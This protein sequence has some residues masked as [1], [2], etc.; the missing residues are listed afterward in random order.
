MYIISTIPLV[1]LAL[2]LVPSL[3][4]LLI[5][6]I[7][8]RIVGEIVTIFSST[9]LLILSVVILYHV[10]YEGS[11]L[12]FGD[13]F[14]VDFL[15]A[16]LLILISFIS[17]IASLYS[18]KYI[19]YE[20]I[21]KKITKKRANMYYALF[22]IFFFTMVLLVTTNNIIIM[23]VALE[24]TTLA[25]AYL[26]AI[27]H[28][29][30]AIEAGWKYVI[31]CSTGIAFGLYG[32]ITL[33]YTAYRS[34]VYNP[35]LWTSLVTSSE[36]LR[37]S[38]TLLRIAF[39]L[40]LIG[41]GTKAGLAPL[42]T[43]LPDAYSEAP[44][45]VSAV[46][47]S[48]LEGC[49]IYAIMRFYRIAVGAGILSFAQIVLIIIGLLSMIISSLHMIVVDDIK[50]MF[51]LS[52]VEHMGL[53]VCALGFG[54]SLGTL[55]AVFHVLNHALVK[56]ALFLST[57]NFVR[58]YGTRKISEIKGILSSYPILGVQL[59]I[60]VYAIIGGPPFGVF[61]SELLSVMAGVYYGSIVVLVIFII[62]LVT[63]FGALL[64]NSMNIIYG[65][66]EFKVKKYPASWNIPVMIL[67][68]ISLLVGIYLPEPLRLC[69]DQASKIVGG[70]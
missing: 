67:L 26:I 10:I 28:S 41:F 13:E 12:C 56:S 2:L 61:Q 1:I 6:I 36:M 29:K 59:L 16:W 70:S 65:E 66:S 53:I 34:G 48:V 40:I 38:P 68:L 50:R 58:A 14:G 64:V 19:R 62:T 47:S 24:A 9:I 8:S 49:A 25:S 31:L 54:G 30:E 57:G 45:P 17:L 32:I 27:Y 15:S 55:A 22:N 60:G 20:L 23:W 46:L 42:H 39:V 11:V 51:A 18:I 43:W 7:K 44:A 21:E 69:L 33:Y 3:S 63:A 52:S 35:L 5:A 37:E 4:A